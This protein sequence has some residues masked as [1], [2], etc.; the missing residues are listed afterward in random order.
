MKQSIIST[1]K[2]RKITFFFISISFGF[3]NG[4]N[5][6][7]NNTSD[8]K[9]TGLKT[10]FINTIY[11]AKK[12]TKLDNNIRSIY[13]DTKGNY[14][15]GTNGSGV[16]LYDGETM[17]QFTTKEGLFNDQIQS[18]QED[19]SGNIWFGT[20][21]F[22][23]SKFD[24]KSFT[25]YTNNENLILNEN[26]LNDWKIVPNDLWFYAGHGVYHYDEAAFKYFLLHKSE[27]VSNMFQNSPNTLSRLAVYSI[28][29]DKKGTLWF[30]T[31]A[32]GVCRYDGKSFT[33]LTDKGLSGP[34]VLG[35]F[36]DSKGNIWIGNNGG[37]LFR[38]DG[39]TLTN[40]TD[41]N[42]LSN[43]EFS[44]SGK[45]NP[46]SLARIYAINEDKK[47]NIWIGTVDAGVWKYDGKNLS[48]YTIKDGLTSNEINT[49][50]KD[51]SGELWFGTDSDGICKFNGTSFVKFEI[52]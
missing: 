35:L 15:F 24:H 23:V 1:K 39:T 33:W 31:Q 18:I 37:G 6:I 11:F 3:C 14:W 26:S 43:K 42:N 48:N 28:L 10:E 41:D 47:G 44:I 27:S 2:F 49:I 12:T 4:Q 16:Y 46:K 51:R 5:N 17:T 29:K 7:K 22:G 52:K 30:G 38:F 45:S 13:Q 36:E 32:E 40:F 8:L 19:N 20:G 25:N 21:L 9:N 34:A 50:Y